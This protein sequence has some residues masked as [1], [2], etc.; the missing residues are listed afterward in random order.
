MKKKT[1]ILILILSI[2]INS[3]CVVWDAAKEALL[4]A[5]KFIKEAKWTIYLEKLNKILKTKNKILNAYKIN[6]SKVKKVITDLFKEEIVLT[7][8]E[9]SIATK[10]PKKK[11]PWNE[12]WSGEVKL[13]KKFPELNK[14]FKSTEDSKYYKK[15]KKFKQFADRSRELSKENKDDFYTLLQFVIDTHKMEN[16]E[17]EDGINFTGGSIKKMREFQN[18]LFKY[19]RKSKQ[20]KMQALLGFIEIEILKVEEEILTAK[21]LMEEYKM[22]VNL[23]ETVLMQKLS[24]LSGEKN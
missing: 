3:G 24:D 14:N 18:K 10:D 9:E 12:I 4:K 7:T 2:F 8:L 5:E 16:G 17:K 11:D 22:K 13:E 6:K 15:D 21:R 19:S 23:R 20:G 1:I